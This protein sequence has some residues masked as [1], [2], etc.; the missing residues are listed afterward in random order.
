MFFDKLTEVGRAGISA[1]SFRLVG[2]KSDGSEV[3]LSRHENE[4]IVELIVQ[5]ETL[6][7]HSEHEEREAAKESAKKKGVNA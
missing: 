2:V 3:I 6:I 7:T 4:G 5:E 1:K